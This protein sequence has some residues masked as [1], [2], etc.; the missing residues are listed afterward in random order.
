MLWYNIG[1]TWV[2]EGDYKQ[3]KAAY[4][5]SLQFARQA[6]DS[7]LMANALKGLGGL[8]MDQGETARALRCL[9]EADAYYS[10]HE[11]QEFR[12]RLE[13]LGFMEKVLTEQKKNRTLLAVSALVLLALTFALQLALRRM[14]RLRR[15]KEAADA[16]IDE[17]L[18]EEPA[19][20]E[21][22]PAPTDDAQLTD[23]E[24]EILSLIAS[25]LTSPQIADKLYL[26]LP[27][28]K[29]YRKRMLGKFEAANSADMI[30]KAKEQGLI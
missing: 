11:D 14:Q 6:A 9:R 26:S 1:E 28:I 16:V 3:A 5:K 4:E 8:Y 17:V 20:E 30:A 12:A 25:G 27:T 21:G 18:Q 7:L 10:L 15:E 29:W 23:R 24:K 19:P 2:D 22:A 13:N